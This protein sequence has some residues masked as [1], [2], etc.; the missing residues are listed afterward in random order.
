MYKYAA[1]RKAQVAL[2]V[3]ELICRSREEVCGRGASFVASTP[4]L[5]AAAVGGRHGR[6]DPAALVRLPA[7]RVA[8]IGREPQLRRGAVLGATQIVRA[9][10]S[11]KRHRVRPC[12]QVL[13]AYPFKTVPTMHTQTPCH[14]ARLSRHAQSCP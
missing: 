9:V 5:A 8:T 6:R 12:S 3:E 4:P 13:L 11:S 10:L 7:R 1:P 14:M 2:V